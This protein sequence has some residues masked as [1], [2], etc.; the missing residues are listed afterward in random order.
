[1]PRAPIGREREFYALLA[2]AEEAAAGR[3]S[4]VFLAGPTGGGKSS[5]IKAL[6]EALAASETEPQPEVV[7]VLC[8]ET[9]AG[10]PLGPFGEVLRALT[11]RE[12][13]GDRAKRVIELVRQIAPP[14][15]ELIPVIGKLAALG[16]KAAADVGV[17]ALGADHQAQ[18][19]QLAS[20]V[21]H[22]LVHVAEEIPLVV[23]V[24]DAQWIDGPSTEV[25]ARLAQ[26]IES[27]RLVLLVAY[28]DDLVDDR[29]PLARLRSA[30]LSRPGD[31]RMVLDDFGREQIEAVLR[32]PYGGIPDARLAEWLLDRTD[33]N[34]LFLE[35]YLATLE[36]RGVLRTANGGW[37]LD[38]S[39]EGGPGDWRLGG[40]L[41][42]AQT[43]NTLLEL[44]RPRLADLDDDERRLLETGA[45]QGRR[46]L[47]AVLVKLL[48]REEDEILDRLGRLE[49]RRRMI[50]IEE[51]EDWWSDR[52]N[53]Y[54]FDPGVLQD[55]L[56][57]R[58]A[59]S[60][61][62]R[63]RRHRA[64]AQTLEALIADDRPP[65][66]HAL[67]EIAHHYERAGDAPAAARR[68]VDVAE[69]TFAEGADR[70]TA[71]FA[72]RAVALL[73]TALAGSLS[74]QARPEAQRLLARAIVLL[75]LGRQPSLQADQSTDGGRHLLELADEAQRAA[76]AVGD[77]AARANARYAA[78]LVLTGYRGLHEGIAAYRE[79]LEL[80]RSAGDSVGQFA[81][82]VNLG[83]Q[84]DSVNLEEGWAVL[85]EAQ[86]L[87]DAGA[88]ARDLDEATLAF[89][90]TR[91]ETMIGVAAF[92]LGR[93]GQAL[94]LLVHG[95][96]A[97][98]TAR[99]RDEAGWAMAFLGQVYTAIGLYEAAEATLREAIALFEDE[100]GSLGLRGY[101][102]AL[103]GHLYVEWDPPR[104]APARE[105]LQRARA[106]AAASGYLAVAPLVD[107]CW[108]EL[109]LAEGTPATLRE[110]DAL[111]EASA[112]FGW[113]RSE[114]TACSLRARIALAEGRLEDAVGL[115]T[116]AVEQL[117]ERGG[118]VPATR[119]EEILF[120][121]V[122]VLEAVDAS[123]APAHAAQA[124]R[125]V[126]AKAA[127]LDDEAQR[128]SF[129]ER[130]RLSRAVLAAAEP[131]GATAPDR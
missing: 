52:S 43:P 101:L 88:L 94:E 90:T 45:V 114:I 29:H 109:L 50:T 13:R 118:A 63:R 34:P 79:A 83:H 122:H 49:E 26:G 80:A 131:E 75:V 24:D 17:Y 102:R 89:E 37:A 72:D 76:D 128:T 104:L 111:L 70:E 112:T 3:G 129:L 42:Q 57:G 44:M 67:L 48:D 32:D 53:L 21:A 78:A 69:S 96:H 126:R 116:R 92:D 14:L 1:M 27:D 35:Q 11:S 6:T 127:S 18:Q 99:R 33:G 28:D 98:R 36:E 123:D 113:A 93:Y 119:S 105:E 46:F 87:L 117:M 130:V 120:A 61:Y 91:L 56:Y 121:H 74:D 68:L 12:R 65:P 9:S 77:L 19:A 40:A 110:A 86:A 7:S 5:L 107:A 31:R 85:Q 2:A 39:I 16:V 59:R 60:A 4:I 115:S 55:L 25:I 47:S 41:A 58:Y 8:Y 73:R 51:T 20:D 125:I 66:R 108:A 22:A 95:S 100:H 15:V 71:D 54:S 103:V 10:N 97:L 23:A 81:I 106:E 30:V 64:V 124:A 38:G 82:L 84:L 62:E